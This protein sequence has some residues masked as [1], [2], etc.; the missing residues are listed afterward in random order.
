MTRVRRHSAHLITSI[1]ALLSAVSI[2]GCGGQSSQSV[3]E[4]GSQSADPS[5][6]PQTGSEEPS[7]S[8]GTGGCVV[9]GCSG[10]ICGEEEV[11][12]T[13]EFRPEYTCYKD[14]LCE[15]QDDGTCG[16]TPTP[17]LEQCLSEGGETGYE[18]C[19]GKACGDTCTVCRPGDPACTELAGPKYC[20][21]DGRCEPAQ[22]EC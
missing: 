12:S 19:G 9:S 20:D 17:R 8:H 13:C 22:P 4:P 16:W 11:M 21:S 5:A 6:E 18:P 10:Q 1:V 7:A 3:A 14:A 2:D 15:R